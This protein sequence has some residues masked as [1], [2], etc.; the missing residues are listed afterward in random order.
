MQLS[1]CDL[2][3]IVFGNIMEKS[4]LI[5]FLLSVEEALEILQLLFGGIEVVDHDEGFF[6][7]GG[8]FGLLAANRYK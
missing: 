4:D 6:D 8:V 5:D 7:F 2:I 1:S 3:L